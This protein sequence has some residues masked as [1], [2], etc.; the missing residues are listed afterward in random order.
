MYER[1]LVPVDGSPTSKLGL[2]HAAGLA[3]HLG[4]RLRLL[5][6]IDELAVAPALDASALAVY[7]SLI[8]ALKEGG[9]RILDEAAQYA[10]KQG[11]VLCEEA[12]VE[13]HGAAVSQAILDDAKRWRADVICMGT[14]GR[15]G[16]NRLLLGSDTARVLR[17]TPVPLLLVRSEEKS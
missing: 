6:V 2:R 13:S 3:K 1:M 10:A 17:E 7:P 15:R 5:H 16:L 14:H 11:V 8:A 4:A 9:R 12:L